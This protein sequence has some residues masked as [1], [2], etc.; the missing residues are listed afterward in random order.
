MSS[1]GPSAVEIKL[2]DTERARLVELSAES[3]GLA[4][5]ARI[6]LACAQSGAGNAQVSRELGVSVHTV[7]KW[8]SV[9]ARGGVQAL[10][11]ESLPGRPKAGLTLSDAERVT[12][13]RWARRAKSSQILAMRSKIVLAC[14]EGKDNK[15]VADELRVDPATVS[16]WR[17]RFIRSRL[18]GL[19]DEQ[20]PGRPP[21]ITLDQVEQVVVATL[22]QTPKNATHWSRA[23]MAERSGLSKST[24]GRIWRDFGLKPHQADT[25]KLSSD[26]LF[27]E[28]VVD[29]V[30]LYHNPPER[31]VVLCV[32]EKSQI[33][34]LDRSQPVLPMM[35][36]M[37]ER[38]THDYVRN[39]ITSLFAAFNIA[40][41]S[42][43]GELHRQHRAAEFKK[44][45]VTIDK[46]VPA[47]LDVHLIC[48]NYGTHK[49]PQIKAWLA[50]H[51][52][53]HMH[54]TP[55]GSSWIN[56][57]ERWFGHLTDQLI[58]RGVHKS[59][60]SLE[61]DIR[62]WIVHWNQNPKPFVWTKTAEEILES[63]AKYLGRISGA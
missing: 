20:R 14:A 3:S 15:Q 28:K 4:V 37:P 59:V 52:R 45:L 10:V 25:F 13:Q 33:Q 21:S 63:L 19:V 12:L 7:R 5:R 50:R 48:D 40:D 26:P 47:E 8:R 53:F 29:V 6:V 16:K 61:K 55:T 62:D 9:F 30:G 57:V 46:R 58:R 38:R 24:I 56:Q 51:P 43:I 23:S 36:G 32:D 27:V 22:E 2:T 54:F 39:G 60:Q 17:S 41:G 31:A 44:F 34:A 11:K 35:P 1:S 18:D 42:V 49:T